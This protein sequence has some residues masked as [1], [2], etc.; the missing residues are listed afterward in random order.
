MTNA[1][2]VLADSFIFRMREKCRRHELESI[3]GYFMV[4]IPDKGALQIFE[5]CSF[6]VNDESLS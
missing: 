4:D 2:V 1:C 6:K 3:P 5:H